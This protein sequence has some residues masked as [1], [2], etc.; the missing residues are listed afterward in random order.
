VTDIL[1][2]PATA[3]DVREFASWRHNPPYDIYDV[4]GPVESEIQYFLNETTNC[5]I[6]EV[7][8]AVGGFITF[9][10]DAQVPG[11]DYSGP[12][13]DIGMGMKPELTGRGYGHLFVDAVARAAWSTFDTAR[14]RV[15][16]A[17]ENRRAVTV[18]E[19]AGFRETQRFNTTG[20]PVM[21]SPMFVVLETDSPPVPSSP[22][23]LG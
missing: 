10:S 2:R 3:D 15:S 5:H 9:G 20:T 14:L 18:W 19:R 21:G 8:G 23:I 13:V 6:I 11:G 4:T 16:V 12:A 1:I 7:D 17:I 22:G